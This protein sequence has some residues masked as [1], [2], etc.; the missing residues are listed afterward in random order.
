MR[1]AASPDVTPEK[2]A[3]STSFGIAA[4]MIAMTNAIETTAPV[5]CSSVRA[6]AAMP[7]RLAG[8]SPIIAAVFG[9]VEE[10]RARR[11]R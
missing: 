6:P 1:K 4:V 8:T 5:F 3:N 11:R 7:R 9:L 10:A 2:M